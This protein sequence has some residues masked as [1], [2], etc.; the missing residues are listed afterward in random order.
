VKEMNT[1]NSKYDFIN[2]PHLT[3]AF[4]ERRK[5]IELFICFLN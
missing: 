4:T 2:G 5:L 3:I 1:I